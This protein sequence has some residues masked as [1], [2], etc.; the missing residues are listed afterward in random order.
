MMK[1]S[2]HR[3]RLPVEAALRGARVT[4]PDKAWEPGKGEAFRQDDH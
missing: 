3:H 4:L 1:N 2:G